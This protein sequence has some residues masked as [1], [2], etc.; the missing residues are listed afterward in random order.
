MG[1]FNVFSSRAW[2]ESNAIQQLENTVKSEGV[3]KGIGMPDMHLGKYGP[4]GSTILS[5]YV[6][7]TL[8]GSDIGCGMSLSQFSSKIK[9][10]KIIKKLNDFDDV[11]IDYSKYNIDTFQESFGTIG[12][13]NHFLEIQKVDKIE[14][15]ELFNSFSLNKDNF[16][17][18]IHT[19]SRGLGRMV[20]NQHIEKYNDNPLKGDEEI[21]SYLKKHDFALNWARLNRQACMEKVSILLNNELTNVFDVPH[22]Y[23]E[24]YKNHYLHR[25]GNSPSNQGLVT[26]AGSR[27]DYS[28]LVKPIESED[29]LYSIAH[30]AG[31]K[32]TRTDARYKVKQQKNKMNNYVICG[33]K[34]L[35]LEEDPSCYKN[36]S[37]VIEDLKNRNLI[38]VVA[39]MK[40]IVTYKTKEGVNN[41]KEIEKNR[42][43]LRKKQREQKYKYGGVL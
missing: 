12:S 33:D 11:S 13:G 31:R 38:E 9:I 20:L 28:V 1:N 29:A 42:D 26:I 32:I 23:I 7:P 4:N 8:A 25:K 34:N 41:R 14:N 24:K 16:Y 35:N 30:G 37:H 19:G 21:Q 36:I 40:P 27:G 2:M 18:L 15:I 17:C 22:N 6:Y 39:W 43:I 10:D 3:I 5:S